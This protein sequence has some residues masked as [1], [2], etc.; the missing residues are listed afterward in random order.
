MRAL[1]NIVKPLVILYLALLGSA[2]A[3][4]EELITLPTRTGATQPYLLLHLN[5]S[6]PSAI[7]ILFPGGN[8]VIGLTTVNGQATLAQKGNFLVRTRS[9]MRDSNVAVAV[10]DAPSDLQNSTGMSDAFRLGSVHSGDMAAVVAD[11]KARFP[12][13]RVYLVGTSRG[14]ISAAATGAALA[15]AVQGVILTS[16]ITVAGSAS[17]PGLT[18]FDYNTLKSPVLMVGHVND[19]CS[20]SPYSGTLA[21]SQKYNYPIVTVNG[22]LAPTSAACDAMSYHDYLGKEAEAVN[23]IKS[24]MLGTTVTT[25]IPETLNPTTLAL[26][27][28]SLDFGNQTV[29]TLAA[30]NAVTLSNTG[31]ATLSIASI[32][33]SGD[34]V[35][36]D[37]CGYSL[38]VGG[39]CAISVTLAASAAGSRTGSITVNSN[40]AGSP[41]TVALSATGTSSAGPDQIGFA[42]L[43]LG[44]AS[45][46]SLS[47]F[48]KIAAADIGQTGSVFLGAQLGSTW[49]LNNGRSWALWT[50][51][52]VPSYASGTLDSVA[53]IPILSNLD[54][55]GAG[56]AN[57]YVG[58]GKTADDMLANGKVRLIYT[59]PTQ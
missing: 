48:V 16:T 30:G 41:H 32:A 53:A 20:V 51:G 12:G 40:A 35:A 44:P 46:R 36:T 6:F 21:V 28:A 38:P 52:P 18:A 11:M 29:G 59:V 19:G 13:A 8:G 56:G 39:N 15:A 23:A 31:N 4:A 17:S 25:T 50:G 22:G 57:V 24:W 34:F 45:Q 9:M 54:V 26:S 47:A 2:S 5:Y 27:P 1:G 58:Y 7:A 3:L 55:R 37:T 43:A 33:A 10:I 49:F 14:T 42:P